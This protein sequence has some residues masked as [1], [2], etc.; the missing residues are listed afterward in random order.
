M[1][2][3][4]D[5]SSPHHEKALGSL[6]KAY[7]FPLYAYL[8]RSGYNVHQAEDYTQAFFAQMLDKHYLSKVGPRP[9]KFRSFLLAALRHFVADEHDR[10]RAVK[11]GG[12]LRKLSFDFETGENQIPAYPIAQGVR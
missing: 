2:A 5:H 3:A 8:R 11:R 4:G 12:G 10:I 9:G 1:L 6:C 7:W